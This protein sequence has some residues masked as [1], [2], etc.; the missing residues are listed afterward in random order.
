MLSVS[1]W[2]Q[3]LSQNYS[4]EQFDDIESGV[5]VEKVKGDIYLMN[6]KEVSENE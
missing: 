1:A 5:F 2:L 4:V 6:H 3:D